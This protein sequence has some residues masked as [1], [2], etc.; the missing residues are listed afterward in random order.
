MAT[1]RY[2][3]TGLLLTAMA[4]AWLAVAGS[5]PDGAAVALIGIFMLGSVCWAAVIQKA[6]GICGQF[7]SCIPLGFGLCCLTGLLLLQAG[8]GTIVSVLGGSGGAVL[9][10]QALSR[11]HQGSASLTPWPA[12]ALTTASSRSAWA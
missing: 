6:L 12:A 9:A 8:M 11:M 10:L 5:P 1:I 7:N 3:L 2:W 4:C